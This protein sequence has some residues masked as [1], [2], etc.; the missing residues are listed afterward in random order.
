M[1]IS[2]MR[3]NTGFWDIPNYRSLLC[4]HMQSS[5]PIKSNGPEPTGLDW[6]KHYS[7]FITGEMNGN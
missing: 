1:M 3:G 2:G 6:S 7:M 5:S 4:T